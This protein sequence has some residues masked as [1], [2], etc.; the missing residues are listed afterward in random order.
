MT[1]CFRCTAR[2]SSDPATEERWR[3]MHQRR[4]HSDTTT[5]VRAAITMMADARR[6][7]PSGLAGPP[8]GATPA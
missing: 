8:A 4:F 6:T 1:T 7:R 5:S 3:E 2:F